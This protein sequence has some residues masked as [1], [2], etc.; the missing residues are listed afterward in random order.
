MLVL[1][2]WGDG[3]SGL[4]DRFIAARVCLGRVG[5][6]QTYQGFVKALRRWSVAE[7]TKALA[8][9]RRRIDAWVRRAGVGRRFGFVALA[10][11][12]SRFDLPRTADHERAFGSIGKR[13]AG[14]LSASPQLWV[15]TLWHMGL[16]IP[17]DWRIGR[18]R[19]S[20]RDH[21]RDMIEATP[22]DALIV[23]D[24]GFTGYDLLRAITDSGRHFLLRVGR[25]VELLRDLGYARRIDAQTVDLWPNFA[26]RQGQP[27]LT[28]RLIRVPA[29]RQGA[30]VRGSA[31]GGTSGGG[32]MWLLTSVREDERL[33]DEQAATLYRM[34]WGVELCYRALKQTLE[35]RKLRAHAADV[36]LFEMHGLL[37][38][39][40]LL[41]LMSVEAIVRRGH[42][43]L[44]WSV[45]GALRVARR[46]L[47]RPGVRHVWPRQL[48][49]AIKDP[50][51]RRRKTRQP[52]PRK[53]RAD[54]PPG[55]PRIRRATLEEVER[56]M[57]LETI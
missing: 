27:P 47:R 46:G 18:A 6:G 30:R 1:I 28:L 17:W 29:R 11:D 45:A 43:P 34:R 9:L 32:G 54:P 55:R 2:A 44:S 13:G 3:P 26:R 10:A 7:L 15:T 56:C 12:G 42:D 51:P 49:V 57:T 23:A 36:A 25:H 31:S 20:E 41:G 5:G 22:T 8:S 53:K 14:A 38:G 16:G 52:W 35:R 4:V 21:L 37:L 39:L 19:A 40:T 24:A 48:A 50:Y 33:G